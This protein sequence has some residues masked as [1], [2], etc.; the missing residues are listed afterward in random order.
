M[1]PTIAQA[2][3][4]IFSQT[5]ENESITPVKGILVTRAFHTF[6]WMRYFCKVG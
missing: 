2:E 1:L 5:K 6:D 4:K 3:N